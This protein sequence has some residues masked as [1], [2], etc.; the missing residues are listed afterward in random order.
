MKALWDEIDYL[1]PLPACTCNGC[2]CTLTM[3]FLKSQQD[4]WLIHFLMK[5]DDQFHQ[6]RT[7]ILMM[8]ELPTIQASY[9]I[10]VQEERNKDI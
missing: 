4:H 5:L 7:N 10:L 9:K 8:I 3:K 2:S 1:D 6:A